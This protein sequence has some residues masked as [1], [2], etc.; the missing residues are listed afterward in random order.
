M[1]LAAWRRRGDLRLDADARAC[2][3]S[4]SSTVRSRRPGPEQTV[5]LNRVE[6]DRETLRIPIAELR[7]STG[8]FIFHAGRET[9]PGEQPMRDGALR[10]DP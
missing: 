10:H 4:R 7:E 6:Y 3:A 8:Y 1:L 9:R 2:S 5:R